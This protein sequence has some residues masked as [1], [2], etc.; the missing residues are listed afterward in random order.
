MSHDESINPCEF[1]FHEEI[2]HGFGGESKYA[3]SDETQSDCSLS[4]YLLSSTDTN[5]SL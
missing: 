2:I 3:D 5:V 1:L 4:Y